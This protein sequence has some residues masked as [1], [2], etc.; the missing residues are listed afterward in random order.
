MKVI[1]GEK[2]FK[3][4]KLVKHLKIYPSLKEWINFLEVLPAFYSYI[5]NSFD[6][7]YDKRY[8]VLGDHHIISTVPSEW[9]IVNSFKKLSII[10]KFIN[11][12]N[13]QHP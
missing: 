13:S 10:S 2:F 4:E 1:I 8:Y 5:E 7:K 12:F 9:K 11:D 6:K 3:N